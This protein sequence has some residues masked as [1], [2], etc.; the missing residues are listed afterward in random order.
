MARI[1]FQLNFS[2]DKFQSQVKKFIDYVL[3]VEKFVN[4]ELIKIDKSKILEIVKK[5]TLKIFKKNKVRTT[6][7]RTVSL[8][9]N[10]NVK[11]IGSGTKKSF[12]ISHNF[13][14]QNKTFA[15]TKRTGQKKT[16]YVTGKTI[17]NTMQYGRSMYYIPKTNE[18]TMKE[19][20]KRGEKKKSKF[21]VWFYGNKKIVYNRMKYGPIIVPSKEGLFFLEKSKEKVE[22][23][24][25]KLREKVKNKIRRL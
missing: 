22:E 9:N 18:K 10:F 4:R 13:L 6:A 7:K 14:T 17:F 20:V 23:F 21:L 11:E 12:V 2:L 5:E 16:Y 8:L 15:F 25:E 3:G 19:I 1:A 24:V